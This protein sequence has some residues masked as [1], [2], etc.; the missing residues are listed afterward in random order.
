MGINSSRIGNRDM[1]YVSIERNSAGFIV[2]REY[3]FVGD[4][5]DEMEILSKEKKI[6]WAK[7]C[8]ILTGDLVRSFNVH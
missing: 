4:F 5:D 2:S 6:I 7:L 3:E 1:S 8:N